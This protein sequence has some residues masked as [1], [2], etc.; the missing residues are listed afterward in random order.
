MFTSRAPGK[1]AASSEASPVSSASLADSSRRTAPGNATGVADSAAA[2]STLRQWLGTRSMT[3]TPAAAASRGSD[4][5]LATS[6]PAATQT[7]PPTYSGSANWRIEDENDSEA[8]CRY[9]SSLPS[10]SARD[11]A[12]K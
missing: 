7:Q 5:A 6:S 1:A 10:P 8:E 12:R 9:T 2:R 4:A 3:V 11:S